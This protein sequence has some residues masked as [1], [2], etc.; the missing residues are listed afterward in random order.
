MRKIILLCAGGM[1]TSILMTKMNNYAKQINYECTVK[2]YAKDRA[3]DV[4][5]DADI[6]MIGPQI[7][8]AME[9]I[10]SNLPDKKIILMN[11]S[12]YGFQR[13]DVFIE[14]VKKEL[15]D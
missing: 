9:E 13:A 5:A 8:Y 2:A 15:G 14:Q 10:Q 6:I 3:A 4:A 12:D 1:S 11:M 7:G